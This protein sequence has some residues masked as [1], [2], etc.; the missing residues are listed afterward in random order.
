[1]NA[2]ERAYLMIL[3]ECYY[4]AGWNTDDREERADRWARAHTARDILQHFIQMKGRP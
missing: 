2:K 1:M 4:R 3:A